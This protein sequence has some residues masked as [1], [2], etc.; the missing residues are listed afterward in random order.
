MFSLL[1]S[2]SHSVVTEAWALIQALPVNEA[3]SSG[4]ITLQGSLSSLG[5]KAAAP[6]SVTPPAIDWVSLLDPS[7]PLKL[8]YSLQILTKHLDSIESPACDVAEAAANSTSVSVAVA[9]AAA[10][11]QSEWSQA[12]IAHG[13]VAH[14][15]SAI[16]SVDLNALLP[17]ATS[18]AGG[19]E[20]SSL[21]LQCL[22]LLLRTF[23]RFVVALSDDGAENPSVSGWRHFDDGSQPT[24]PL[25]PVFV[26]RMIEVL[27]AVAAITLPTATDADAPPPTPHALALC[28]STSSASSKGGAPSPKKRQVRSSG[29]ADA[30][31]SAAANPADD[32]F[33]LSSFFGD[34]DDADFE[35][36]PDAAAVVPSKGDGDTPDSPLVAIV[37]HA[38]SEI[39]TAAL[40]G[41]VIVASDSISAAAAAEQAAG[42]AALAAL[43]SFPDAGTVLALALLAP[44]E[45]KV[46]STIAAA[47]SRASNAEA[48]AVG[49]DAPL[50]LTEFILEALLSRI[51]L[52]YSL[53][54]HPLPFFF[55]IER[56]LQ[57]SPACVCGC[58]EGGG[59]GY[60]TFYFCPRSSAAALCEQAPCTPSLVRRSWHAPCSS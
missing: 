29:D 32:G 60:R 6:S 43:T 13:G 21:S 3:V 35:T 2:P 26:R 40:R 42:P 9:G 45:F 7:A 14:L 58:G 1:S 11:L 55:I 15:A 17:P 20:S 50:P 56:I 54:Q 47:L 19:G 31:R 38:V 8:L 59:E 36:S 48:A 41:P 46:K 57:A 30:A 44:A 34:D 37:R 24:E 51:Q 16:L 5:D 52:A 22:Q 10:V 23:S 53:P 49:A 18:G 4:I 39:L 25:R 27:A 28:R 12:F 33:G